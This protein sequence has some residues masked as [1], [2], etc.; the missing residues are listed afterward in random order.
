VPEGARLGVVSYL[1]IGLRD[2]TRNPRRTG[3]TLASIAVGIG[4]LTLLSAFRQGWVQTMQTGFILGQTGHVQVHAAGFEQSQNLTDHIPDPAEVIAVAERDPRAAAV[5]VRARFSGLATSAGGSAG[6]RVIA[7]DPLREPTVTRLHACLS[8]GRWLDP[9]LPGEVILGATLAENLGAALGDRVVLT[10]QRP[11]GQMASEVFRL[12]AVL[13]PGAPEADRTRA[14]IGLPC[15]QRWL[16]LGHGV[17]DVVV[18]ARAHDDAPGVRER[19]AAALPDGHYEVLA[20]DALDP[21]VRQWL[22]FSEAYSV[23][24]V[25]VVTGLVVAQVANTLLMVLHERTPELGLL[26]ALGLR[27]RQLAGLVLAEGLVVVLAGG[28]LGLALGGV[29]VHACSG[30]IELSGFEAAVG[31]FHMSPTIQPSVTADTLG[32]ILLTMLAAALLA[33]AYPALRAARIDPAQALRRL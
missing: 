14:I 18:R 3:L 31:V 28:L 7:A 27:Q 9:A 5:T 10:A 21:M 19:I 11:D 15:A 8:A 1:R 29:A 26:G 25:L 24:I 13:C 23:V 6:V 17:T 16:G 2:L 22:R 20:W 32:L 30:G 33:G 4:A 12:G